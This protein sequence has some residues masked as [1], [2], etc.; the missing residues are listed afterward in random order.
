RCGAD[1]DARR[2]VVRP[3]PRRRRHTLRAFADRVGAA[4]VETT[5]RGRID[6]RGYVA[7]EHDAFAPRLDLRIGHGHGRDERLRVGHQRLVVDRVCV[8]QLDHLAEVHYGHAVGDVADGAQI[9]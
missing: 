8:G 4:R 3:A 2:E 5:T 9:V 1:A 6:R 7:F